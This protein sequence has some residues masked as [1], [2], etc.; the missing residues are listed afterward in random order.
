MNMEQV[1]VCLKNK[2][3]LRLDL[4]NTKQKELINLGRTLLK[5]YDNNIVEHVEKSLY[6]GASQEEILK[7]AEFIIGDSH[8]FTSV[9]E[10]LNAL[11]YEENKRAECISV[12]DD[13]RED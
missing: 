8:L 6:A 10:L 3:G 1:L 7:V 2:K 12:L 9:I 4:L 13:V 5:G 11:K